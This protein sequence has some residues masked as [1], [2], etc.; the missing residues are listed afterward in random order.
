VPG[1]PFKQRSYD[2]AFM[3]LEWQTKPPPA[4]GRRGAQRNRPANS[5]ERRSIATWSQRPDSNWSPIP[6]NASRATLPLR[7]SYYRQSNKRANAKSAGQRQRSC[8][9]YIRSR[10]V[11]AP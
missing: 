10:F 5:V 6:G 1:Q 11:V 8:A 4:P 3:A 2:V 7:L 9:V